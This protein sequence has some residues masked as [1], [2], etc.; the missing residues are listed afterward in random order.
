MTLTVISPPGEAALSLAQAKA[1]LLVGHEGEDVL[2]ADL[3]AAA[4]AD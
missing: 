1:F 4:T 2:V 3:V